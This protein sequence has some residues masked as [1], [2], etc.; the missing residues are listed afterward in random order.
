LSGGVTTGGIVPPGGEVGVVGV[1]GEMGGVVTGGVTTGGMAG[2]VGE[3]APGEPGIEG[4]TPDVGPTKAVGRPLNGG[5][6]VGKLKGV[7]ASAPVAGRNE[8]SELGSSA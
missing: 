8:R 3:V 5:E 7:G 4:V 6:A 1:V 2:V